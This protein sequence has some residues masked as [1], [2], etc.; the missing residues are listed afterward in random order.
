MIRALVAVILFMAIFVVPAEAQSRRPRETVYSSQTV[1]GIALQPFSF[2]REPQRAQP[3][4]VA[5]YVPRDRLVALSLSN[6]TNTILKRLLLDS[7]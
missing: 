1:D 6:V 5:Y 3:I 4:Q 2:N 7:M